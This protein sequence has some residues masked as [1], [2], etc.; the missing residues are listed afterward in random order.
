MIRTITSKAY[1]REIAERVRKYRIN[2]GMTQSELATRSGV[3]LRSISRF[4]QGGDIQLGN[5]IKIMQALGLQANLEMIIPDVS[6]YPSYR[7][8]KNPRQRVR[9]M[10]AQ[11]RKFIWGDEQ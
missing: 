2:K 1:V 11:N 4:E 10:N 9:S 6:N 8:R 7:V 3:S 5:L